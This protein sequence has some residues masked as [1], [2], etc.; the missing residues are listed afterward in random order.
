[1]PQLAS[2]LRNT[3]DFERLQAV[4]AEISEVAAAA[5]N[6][7]L[8]AHAAL[9]KLWIQLFTNPEG[10]PEAVRSETTRAISVFEESGDKRGLG[11]AW[12]LL[13]LMHVLEA[14]F[15]PAEEAWEQ[16]AVHAA[17]AGERRDELEALSWGLLSVW[18]GP[19][20]AE[21]GLERSREMLE[22]ARGDRKGMAS[23][24]FMRAVFEA[25]LGRFD[26]ARGLIAEAKALL[27]E[28]GLTVWMAGPLTQMAGLVE[29]LADDP[30]AAERELRWGYETLREIGEVAWLSTLVAILAEAVYAQSRLDEAEQLATASRDSAGSEDVYSQILW[31][32]VQARV[33]ARRGRLE[34]AASLARESL[35]LAEQT[36]SLGLRATA[37]TCLAEVLGRSGRAQEAE[38]IVAQ[39]VPLFERKGNI[40]AARQAR[41]LLEE[42]PR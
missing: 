6:A 7:P 39:A 2:A 35:G 11:E 13:G 34:E 5:G 36:D 4:V 27:R 17:A 24:L 23:A 1:M 8:L 31:R 14:Q 28:I 40:V 37:L 20:N 42:L 38:A 15:G 3:G 33:L 19:A 16:A 21:Q 41:R 32:A 22:R 29:L 12:S 9:L 26:V 30:A 10:W 18:A 25:G